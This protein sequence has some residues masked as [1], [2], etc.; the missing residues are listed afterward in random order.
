MYYTVGILFVYMRG[1]SQ[2]APEYSLSLEKP[3]TTPK[4][5]PKRT[6][7]VLAFRI[8][9][10][11]DVKIGRFGCQVA[12]CVHKQHTNA[13]CGCS[14]FQKFFWDCLL[15]K[16]LNYS[17][18]LKIYSTLCVLCGLGNLSWV[19]TLKYIPPSFQPWVTNHDVKKT[20]FKKWILWS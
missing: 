20:T 1:S 6:V 10:T 3:P 15:L 11:L 7:S 8:A 9:L 18:K 2:S 13:I 5:G 12:V 4:L 19:Q 14:Q 17:Q 16:L